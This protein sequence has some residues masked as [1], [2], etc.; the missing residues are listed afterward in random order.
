MWQLIAEQFQDRLVHILLAEM[1][2]FV[3]WC[4]SAFDPPCAVIHDNIYFLSLVGVNDAPALQQAAIGIAMGITGTE[5]SKEAADMILAD[6]HFSTIAAGDGLNPS[7]RVV[8]NIQHKYSLPS[9]G[10]LASSRRYLSG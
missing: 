7:R 4:V 1:V 6:D 8:Y 9:S 10:R 3:L 2:R 5:V